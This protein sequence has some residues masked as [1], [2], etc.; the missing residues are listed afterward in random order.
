[1][2]VYIYIYIYDYIPREL[3]AYNKHFD[4]FPNSLYSH[5]IIRL[6]GYSNYQKDS[7]NKFDRIVKKNG[8]TK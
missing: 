2:C 6:L 3:N 4:N 5:S 8:H 1:M 7:I